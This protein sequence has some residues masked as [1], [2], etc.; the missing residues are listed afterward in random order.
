MLYKGVFK[1]DSDM[2]HSWPLFRDF[3]DKVCQLNS[4]NLGVYDLCFG[5]F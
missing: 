3:A 2:K 1:T 4:V 5:K